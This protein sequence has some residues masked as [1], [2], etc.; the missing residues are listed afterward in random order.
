MQSQIEE[1]NLV[2]RFCHVLQEKSAED[3][4]N[5]QKGDIVLEYSILKILPP[6]QYHQT[7]DYLA[8]LINNSL[9]VRGFYILHVRLKGILI[10]DVETYRSFIEILAR[11]LRDIQG[12][13]ICHVH[14]APFFFRQILSI[15]SVFI[16]KEVRNKI[17]V[18]PKNSSS[19]TC[20]GAATCAGDATFDY[21]KVSSDSSFYNNSSS[22]MSNNDPFV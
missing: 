7:A 10:R 1:E 5:A 20:T 16:K 14:D 9:V 2:Q 17:F 4:V 8:M 6:S 18:I 3:I 12:L 15:L 19:A 11:K 21:E 13:E 22:L